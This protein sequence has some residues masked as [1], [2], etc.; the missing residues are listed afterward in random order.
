LSDIVLGA[1]IGVGG[2]A[3][4]A[5]ITGFINYKNARLQ[6]SH[7]EKEAQRNR[8]VE[9]RKELLPDLR[10]T[11]SKLVDCSNHQ[12]AMI[13]RL[14]K[15]LKEYKEDSLERKLEIKEFVEVSERLKE[16][17]SE[18][19]I[20][21]EQ[22]SDSKLD[23]LIEAVKSKQNEVDIQRMPLIRFFN[24]PGGA[25]INTLESAFKKDESLLKEVRKQVLQVNKRIE[26]LLSGEPSN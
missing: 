4:G 19:N 15:A 24:N 3:L 20:L 1:L 25:D 26:E 17:S 9:A 10:R 18:F 23:D 22:V 13:I 16:L 2:V 11:I 12:L 14:D 5:I 6:L 21:R 8:L 7:Q